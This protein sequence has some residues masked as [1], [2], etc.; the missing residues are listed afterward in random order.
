M[1][2]FQGEVGLRGMMGSPGNTGNN[3]R[4]VYVHNEAICLFLFFFSFCSLEGNSF[5]DFTELNQIE[6]D[7]L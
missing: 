7:S 4:L 5:K 6:P 2:L 3:V 1:F